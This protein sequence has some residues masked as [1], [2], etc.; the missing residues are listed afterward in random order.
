MYWFWGM[1]E[2]KLTPKMKINEISMTAPIGD[3]FHVDF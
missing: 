3:L 2:I 1:Y